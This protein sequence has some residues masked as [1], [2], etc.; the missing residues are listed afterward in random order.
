MKGLQEFL[1]KAEVEYIATHDGGYPQTFKWDDD[2]ESHLKRIGFRIKE[3]LPAIHAFEDDV[4]DV[5]VTTSNITV[6]SK[7][8]FIIMGVRNT[9]DRATGGAAKSR[10]LPNN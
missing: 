4:G 10:V 7:N 9:N 5:I 2:I 3:R 8:G 6:G 1:Q